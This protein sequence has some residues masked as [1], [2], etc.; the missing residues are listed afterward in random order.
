MHQLLYRP[1][2]SIVGYIELW[3]SGIRQNQAS[4]TL[5]LSLEEGKG[6]SVRWGIRNIFLSLLQVT[7]PIYIDYHEL[8]I[9]SPG[10]FNGKIFNFLTYISV[11]IFIYT[12]D[13]S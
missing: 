9:S 13:R 8:L 11:L 7:N 10:S 3:T 2:L 4:V 12:I 5:G 1:E 6:V